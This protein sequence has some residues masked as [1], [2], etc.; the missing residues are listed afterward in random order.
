[1]KASQETRAA[2]ADSITQKEADK[3]SWQEKIENAKEEQLSSLDAL[4]KVLA[5]GPGV[6]V[7]GRRVRN[8]NSAA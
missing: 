3:A 5:G 1:M 2:N 7:F 6:S 4:E 8:R